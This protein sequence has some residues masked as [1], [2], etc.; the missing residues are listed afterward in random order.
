MLMVVAS[1]TKSIKTP[2]TNR[3]WLLNK[4]TEVVKLTFVLTC[5]E[6]LTVKV[7]AQSSAE[8]ANAL[9]TRVWSFLDLIVLRAL[10]FHRQASSRKI[11]KK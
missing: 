1:A 6:I 9:V 10:L 4:I 3:K 11:R 7:P 5:V 8:L 2:F